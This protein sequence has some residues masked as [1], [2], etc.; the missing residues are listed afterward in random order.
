MDGPSKEEVTHE[1]DEQMYLPRVS[2]NVKGALGRGG[3]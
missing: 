3:R 1:R 2:K